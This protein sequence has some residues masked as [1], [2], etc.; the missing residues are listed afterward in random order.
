M[1]LSCLT[2]LWL[3]GRKQFLW[4]AIKGRTCLL[5]CNQ[6]LN[7]EQNK[8]LFAHR[9]VFA[10]IWRYLFIENS[11]VVTSSPLKSS[12]CQVGCKQWPLCME[13]DAYGLRRG[14]GGKNS[15]QMPSRVPLQCP[16][17][18]GWWEADSAF[19]SVKLGQCFPDVQLLTWRCG[20]CYRHRRFAAVYIHR[21]ANSKDAQCLQVCLYINNWIHVL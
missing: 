5:E 6:W 18:A 3:H 20:L 16:T 19:I 2:G 7:E 11:W 8:Y 13:E 17:T 4:R 9:N 12:C 15:A 14:A 10:L 21:D 1:D